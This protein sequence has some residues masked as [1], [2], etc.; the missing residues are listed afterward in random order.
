ML[1]VVNR[2]SSGASKRVVP[3]Q[4][5][6]TLSS[7]TRKVDYLLLVRSLDDLCAQLALRLR[8]SLRLLDWDE[9]LDCHD[10]RGRRVLCYP[11]G[12]PQVKLVQ[13]MLH[14]QLSFTFGV[15]C[16][17]VTAAAPS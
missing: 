7:P 6:S 17:N 5:T 4:S 8:L 1:V 3:L 10:Y 14:M 12:I 16:F 13:I 11:K 15:L 9:G 2:S